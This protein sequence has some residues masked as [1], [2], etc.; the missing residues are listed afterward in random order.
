MSTILLI[1]RTGFSDQEA[2]GITM[3]NLL[4]AWR[5]DEKAE[6]YCD[7][8][9]PD[10]SAAYK[11][12]RTTDM[13]ML[14][15]FVGKGSGTVFCRTTSQEPVLNSKSVDISIKTSGSSSIPRWMK[16]RK[17]DFRLK[18]LREILWFFSP[19]GHRKLENWI[20]EVSPDAVVYM[21]GESIFL[22]KLVLHVC[23]KRL[24]PLV[25]YNGEAFR[26]IDIKKRKGLEREYYRYIKRLYSK[27]NRIACYVIYNCE[28]LKEGYEQEYTPCP[29]GMVV[30]N[31]ADIHC[32][33]YIAHE[34]PVITYF[35]NLG[36]GRTGSLIKM[37]EILS[38][39]DHSVHI[40]VY[41]KAI[42]SDEALIRQQKNLS[43]HG[44]ISADKLQTVIAESD[45]LIHTESFQADIIDK[46]RY[47]FSTKIAQCLHAGRCLL[48]YIPKESA[49]AQYLLKE[50]CAVVATNENELREA[51]RMLLYNPQERVKFAKAAKEIGKKNHDVGITS[52]KVHAV[53]ESA[54]AHYSSGNKV[55]G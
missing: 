10:Y 35:G 26:L 32:S 13:D 27:L 7:V 36:V 18:W 16:Q 4:S 49:S 34:K 39:I 25:L 54:I 2:N 17:Y 53:I 5:P 42:Q 14:K 24:L 46:L 47:A 21:V 48:S 55:R 29:K 50:R 33:D 51:W 1:S 8:Q 44:L 43:Y 22:D 23:Q 19:W 40:D 30:Y 6:F 28:M 45:I 20:T 52:K 11:Y 38:E 12:F 9:P 41:G 3:K 15:A 37:A 31:S